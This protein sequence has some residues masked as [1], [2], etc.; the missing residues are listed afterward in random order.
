MALPNK[1]SYDNLGGELKDYSIATDP[2]TDLSAE[3]SNEARSDT[4]A[5]TRTCD[6]VW[7]SFTTDTVDIFIN[8]ADHDAVYGNAEIYKPV[9]V[10]NGI[11]NYTFTLPTSIIDARGNPQSIN[12]K[13][14]HGNIAEP[15]FSVSV[16]V[17]TANT[18]DVYV[19]DIIGASA[20]DPSTSATKV[21]IFL[22]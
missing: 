16:N 19:T 17:L 3:A 6:K 22:K 9:G 21:T 4:A 2:T 1:Q 7:F 11:G 12:L 14:G 5:M 10:Y 18:V 15:A 20:G 13:C 8:S